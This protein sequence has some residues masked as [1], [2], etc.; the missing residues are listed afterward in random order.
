MGDRRPADTSLGGGDRQ[1]PKTSWSLLSGLG[2]TGR[3]EIR[4]GMEELCRR[5][6]K[7]L[8]LYARIA[9]AKSNEEAKDLTQAFFVWVMEG[10][11]IRR[12][13]PGRAGFRAYL[14]GL[15]RNFI[16][17]Q[18]KAQH[19]LKRGGG[20]LI[21]TLDEAL[22]REG[23]TAE[24][25]FDRAW[26]DELMDRAIERVRALFVETGREKQFQVFEEYDLKDNAESYAALGA[27]LGLPESGISNALFAAREAVRNGIRDELA[28]LTTDAAGIEDEW[29]ELF[30]K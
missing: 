29:N 11:V 24:Q 21:L 26:R 28:E 7:P 3:S 4:A 13:V 30:G 5:Y 19:R 23:E 14:K 27:R 8:Y 6:W 12:F 10:D 9:W 25:G 17:D 18:E 22:L 16:A 2:I 15:L 20:A 1:F